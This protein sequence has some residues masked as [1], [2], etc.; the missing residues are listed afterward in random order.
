M[1]IQL[2]IRYHFLHNEVRIFKSEFAYAVVFVQLKLWIQ[3]TAITDA[4]V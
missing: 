4:K 1:V 2:M 3:N